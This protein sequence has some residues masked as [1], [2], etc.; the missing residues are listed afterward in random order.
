MP[1]PMFTGC[2]SSP[3]RATG[4]P[5]RGNP[6]AARPVAGSGTVERGSEGV[7]RIPRCRIGPQGARLEAMRRSMTGLAQ[8]CH[9]DDRPDCPII[10][11]LAE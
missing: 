3:T 2:G 7:G 1:M 4:I 5:D 10:E 6:H 9:G 11:R 8:A